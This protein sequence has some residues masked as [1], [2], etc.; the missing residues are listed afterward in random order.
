M[1]VLTNAVS[2]KNCIC[3]ETHTNV[4]GVHLPFHL[5]FLLSY[6]TIVRKPNY[7]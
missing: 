1:I 3:S 7:I 6:F 5:V 2:S 4:G